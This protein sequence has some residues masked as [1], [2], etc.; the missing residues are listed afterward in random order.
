[1]DLEERTRLAARR[2]PAPGLF[3]TLLGRWAIATLLGVVVALIRGLVWLVENGHRLGLTQLLALLGITVAA[4]LLFLKQGTAS[5]SLHAG[6]KLLFRGDLEGAGATFFDVLDSRI[7]MPAVR[8]RGAALLG[9]TATLGGHADRA[10]VLLRAAAAS[11][12]T[13]YPHGRHLVAATATALLALG[14]PADARAVLAADRTTDFDATGAGT[15]LL[16]EALGG[17][18]TDAMRAVDRF[19]S[20]SAKRHIARNIPAWMRD[21]QRA[22]GWLVIAYVWDRA[23]RALPESERA[24]AEK[25]RAEALAQAKGVP[26]HFHA[27]LAA[28]YPEF[29]KLARAAS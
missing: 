6:T 26:P 19:R 21:T 9:M 29:A 7:V 1:M 27:Y 2:V 10:I 11:N 18:V 8:A 4:L 15:A 25:K 22:Y 16:I 28:S 24:D 14:R 17:T 23:A 5:R 12:A 3:A 20:H 13:P